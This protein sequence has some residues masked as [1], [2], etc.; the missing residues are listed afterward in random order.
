MNDI[1]KILKAIKNQRW[2]FF[3]NKAKI[4]FDRDTAL[5]WAN[6]DHF[7]YGYIGGYSLSGSGI[8][9]KELLQETNKLGL[10]N[11]KNW[12]IP[13]VTELNKIVSGKI[14]FENITYYEMQKEYYW[15]IVDSFARL[16]PYDIDA[17][18]F[19]NFN[20]NADVIPCCYDL[21]P[22]SY[23]GNNPEEVL[24]IFVDNELE[25]IFDDNA[26]TKL[27]LEIYVYNK[28]VVPVKAP[29]KVSVEKIDYKS[30]LAN[31]D[32]PSINNSI[33][34]YYTAIKSL[35]DNLL[36]K[37]TEYENA[38]AETINKFS[39][40][41]LKLS[42]R[43][44]ENSHLATEE[45]QLLADRQNFLAQ[46]LQLGLDDAK[47]Q[48]ISVKMQ[49][50]AIERSIDNINHD[51]NSLINLAKLTEIKRAEFSLVVENLT[52]I[53]NKA[54]DKMNFAENHQQFIT[55][56]IKFWSVFDDSYRAF[57]TQ[58]Y[59]ELKAACSNDN[60][61]AEIFNK[62]YADWQKK[63]FL[64]EQQFLTLIA[65][66]LKGHLV[67]GNFSALN[68]L[69]C[70]QKYKMAIDNFYLKERKYIYQKAIIK[71]DDNLQ[72]KIETESE[73]YKLTEEF[74]KAF[75][76]IIFSLPKS[77]ERIFL[78]K[79]S[80]P[81]LNLQI[82]E[83]LNFIQDNDLQKISQ[84]VLNQFME[85]RRQ[86]FIAYLSDSKAYSDAVQQRDKEYNSLIF[87]MRKDLMR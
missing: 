4:V 19:A 54:L 29:A 66:S 60:I 50:E 78:M 22:Q 34:Q 27:Y 20:V 81:L 46:N 48:I 67:D 32:V 2:Y 71:S 85:L 45:N 28:S 41:N 12:R 44:I 47:N 30:L 35:T 15:T 51:N 43:Y 52:H 6:L 38:K 7:N 59:E 3:N 69:A 37:L 25:P 9:I 55:N 13:T 36:D 57:K 24:K 64:I 16:R 5:L 58:K 21:V 77:E 53:L 18:G 82:D 42:A 79:W 11:Y 87:R 56:L 74:Q 33:I 62:W 65:F 84:E 26:I 39:E 1:N 70:L 17:N 68:V 14:S 8:K 49:A 83:I 23:N 75:Q 80:E 72:E 86:N 40:I 73:L 10:D 76:E 63:R 31:Y 61:E